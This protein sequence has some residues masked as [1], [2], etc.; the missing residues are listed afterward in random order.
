MHNLS[1]VVRFVWGGVASVS[2]C[3]NVDTNVE[4][5]L[6]L[7][8]T[9]V[10]VVGV[11]SNTDVGAEISPLTTG[12]RDELSSLTTSVRVG[13]SLVTTGVGV[14]RVLVPHTIVGGNITCC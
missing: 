10:E 8:T 3:S 9:G 2:C 13:L 12:I 7:Q 11:L 6:S 4:S 5:G 14:V 1:F